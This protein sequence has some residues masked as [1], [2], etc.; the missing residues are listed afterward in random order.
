MVGCPN[1]CGA[2]LERGCVESHSVNDC[3]LYEIDCTFLYAGCKVKLPRKDMPAH[4]AD[5]LADHMSLQQDAMLR[6]L[7]E[8]KAEL[9]VQKTE[10]SQ[11]T[12]L[13]KRSNLRIQDL[14]KEVESLKSQQLEIR[15]HIRLTPIHFFIT[16]FSSKKRNKKVW[17]SPPFYTHPH[18]YKLCI[19][20]DVNGCSEG[21]GTHISIY[22]HLMRGEFDNQLK[23]PFCG[24]AI[25]QL[26]SQEDDN[27]VSTETNFGKV[28]HLGGGVRLTQQNMGDGWGTPK[29]I[30]HSDLCPKYL[31]NDTLYF[32]VSSYV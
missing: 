27:H 16:D 19:D 14:E 30:A 4:I 31:K 21:E 12:E 26:L 11:L 3:P 2:K 20:V 15:T 22:V 1:R 13:L 9:K 18:G 32:K 25:V 7:G 23:W 17:N 24:R 10:H 6:E 8:L 29:Y 28:V 5:S